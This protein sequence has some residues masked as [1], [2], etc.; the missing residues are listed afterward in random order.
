MID[1]NP[2]GLTQQQVAESRQRHGDNIITPPKDD[3]AWKLFIEKFKDP[4]IQ[5]LLFAAVLSLAIAFVEKDFTESIGIICAIILATC[6]GFWFEWD[7]MRRFRRLNRVNDD[8]P[9]KVVRDGAVCEVPR[10]DV[11]VGDLVCIESGETVP[12]DGELVEAVSLSINESTLTGE[13][14]VDKTT[15]ETHFDADATYP[16][17]AAMRGTTVVDGYGRMVVTAVGDHTEAGRVT[18]QSTIES[19]EQTPLNRQLTRLSRLIGKLGIGLSCAIF[20]VML[21]KAI[22]AGHLLEGDWLQISQQVL[23]IFMISVA[24]I[25][26]A[27]PE[28]LPMSITLSLAMSMRRMLKT[29]NLV[30]KMH[31]CE[32]MGA[33][34]VICTDKT[35]TLTQNKMHV[36]ELVRYDELSE[37]EFAEIIALNS[38]AFLDS[39]GKIIGNPTEGAL[40]EWMR[41]RG[42]SYE[43]LR[44]GATIVD[45][46]T[47]STERKYMATIIES[48]ISGRRILCVKGAPEIVRA[49]S[50]PDGRDEEVSERLLAF[51]N[52]AM[53]TLGIAWRECAEE[54]VLQA[55]EAGGLR[56][57]A[58]AAI[59]DPVREDVPAAVG[60]CLGAGIA[61]KIVTGDTP[62]TAREIARQI[63]LWNDAVDGE[64][65]HMTGTEFAAMSDEELLDRVGELKI[66]SRA[67]PLDKQR[68][69]RLL[70]QRGEVVAVTGDGTNDAPALNFANVGLSMGSG[71][72]VAKDASDIT[73]LDDSFASIAT[74]VMWG[75]SL[76]RNIQRFVLFQLTINFAAIVICFVGAIFGTD[77]PLTVVQILWV[78][79]IM[80]TFAAMAM[81][82]L[83]PNPEVMRDKPRPRNE[84]I[85]TPAMARTLFTCGGVMV[86]VL[87]GMLFYWSFGSG[88]MTVRELT[89]FFSTFVFMQLW[90][91]F[92]AK[93]FE[94][95]HPVFKDWHGCRE[96]FLILL[97]IAVG[98]VLIVE[99]GGAVF[100]TVPLSW[101]EWAAV[102]GATSLIAFGGEAV[103]ALRRRQ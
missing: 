10:R 45:R 50:L 53:R 42:E 69:V 58:V 86:V 8:I 61:I 29:H 3:S 15:D 81:A 32:T 102:I 48:G 24:I 80:D 37:Q 68:L 72:S 38:T 16:S 100:R 62:A 55:V 9:V 7:A 59:S 36:G 103:R 47:F 23:H 66:M 25:V 19:D 90:N 1:Y 97:A 77:M 70:Q 54:D 76:Y 33:V 74:A 41:G 30:R 51:Q 99:F 94:T 44:E 28:G 92:N 6:V 84:F 21:G 65:N 11:V 83:P 82:S 91:M 39:E 67:R 63:G 101:G 2:K 71:T 93:G 27:V 89:L 14:S 79:I 60:R 46:L 34:T 5:V 52:R 18:E 43:R 96:F 4:I 17:N 22:F 88:E 75:R 13:P 64:R 40:L 57:A 95:H 85:I 98:Q 20:C 49:M 26:M 31:A 73:L 35:G 78:N 12:A 56:F 87:L